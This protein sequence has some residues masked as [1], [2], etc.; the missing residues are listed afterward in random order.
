MF[1]IVTPAN[2]AD[3]QGLLDEMYEMRYRVVV[4]Q[5]GWD[6]PGIRAGYDRDQFDTADTVYVIVQ[7]EAGEVAGTSRLNPTT[8]PHMLSELFADRCD[9]QPWPVGPD[10]WECSRFVVD[11][12]LS[13][14]PVENFRIRCR[15]GMGLIA[16]SLDHGITR[17]S[18]L[19]HQKFYNLVQTV[20][21]TEPLGLPKRDGEDWAWIPAVSLI[22]Q[23]TLDRQLDRFRNAETIV[24]QSLAPARVVAG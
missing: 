3:H 14:D 4:D 6:I 20:W 23:E 13:D 17:L 18:W 11:R 16:W 9:L 12:K 5:W 22:D 15:T 2:R 8:A 21:K 10:V 19:T 24:Q 1:R 7:N